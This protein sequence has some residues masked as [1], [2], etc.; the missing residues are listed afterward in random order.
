MHIQ[1]TPTYLQLISNA[2]EYIWNVFIRKASLTNEAVFRIT[3]CVAILSNNFAPLLVPDLWSI[4]VVHT[5]LG[6]RPFFRESQLGL[7]DAVSG[8]VLRSIHYRD[9]SL[10]TA[11]MRLLLAPWALLQSLS[12][13][14]AGLLPS[15]IAIVLRLKKYNIYPWHHVMTGMNRGSF[16]KI[17]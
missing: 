12:T 14:S 5:S 3:P 17:I 11:W 9:C 8:E 4:M 13:V 16:F 6:S 7:S 15:G 1:K 10:Q 2:K